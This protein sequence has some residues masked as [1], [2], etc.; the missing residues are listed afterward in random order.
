MEQGSE[1]NS[2]HANREVSKSI[3]RLDLGGHCRLRLYPPASVRP[4]GL[5]YQPSHPP[6]FSHCTSRSFRVISLGDNRHSPT[7]LRTPLQQPASQDLGSLGLR[8]RQRAQPEETTTTTT[9][10]QLAREDPEERRVHGRV[11]VTPPT[12]SRRVEPMADEHEPPAPPSLYDFVGEGNATDC[13]KL[14]VSL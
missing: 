10:Q 11:L 1:W 7:T 6:P 8:P 12:S 14:P 9:H 13:I 4:V 3:D 2:W 5:L